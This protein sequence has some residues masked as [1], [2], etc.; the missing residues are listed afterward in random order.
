[1][2]FIRFTQS[3][4]YQL[5]M[6]ETGQLT[7]I[8]ELLENEYFQNHPYYGVFLEQLE[9]AQARTPHPAW[10]TIEEIL[11]EVGYSIVAG[12]MEAQEALDIAAAQI[13]ELLMQ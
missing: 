3:D 2:E 11:T 9:T 10:N 5:K 4:E 8:P 6:S 1:M 12:E 7:V 13:D